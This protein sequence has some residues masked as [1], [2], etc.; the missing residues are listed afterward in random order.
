MQIQ[1][2]MLIQ[3]IAQAEANAANYLAAANNARGRADALREILAVMDQPEETP[4]KEGSLVE[5]ATR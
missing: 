4:K 3:Q 5:P 2:E 1:K